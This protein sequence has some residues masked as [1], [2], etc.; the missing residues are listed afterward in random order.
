[1]EKI[2][3]D[4]VIELYLSGIGSTTIVKILKLPKKSILKLLKEKGLIRN[5][6]HSEEFYSNFWE[7]NG[8]WCG[9]WKCDTCERSIKFTVNNKS[10][11]NRNI[12]RKKTCKQCSLDKQ[13]GDGNPFYGKTHTQETIS[14]ISKSRIGQYC[15]DNHHMK[16]PEKLKKHTEILRE[17]WK[18]GELDYLRPIRRD[19]MI[20]TRLE[21]KLKS[22]IRSKAEDEIILA[23]RNN[24][25]EVIPNYRIETKIFD[26]Y[27][28]K[29]NLLIEYNG[30]YWHCN[31]K[32][33]DAD[34][35]NN[36]KFKTAKEI[37]EYDK[38]KLY[39]AK[40]NGYVCEVI[41]EMDYK[42][43]KDIVLE[44]IKKYEDK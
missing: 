19:K 4:K 28:P 5:R 10:L 13:V 41:W 23:L 26:L 9:Y 43:N 16:N 11:L 24:L 18:S 32:K 12:K 39:L 22:F 35:Y 34:Y 44:I 29:Y 36:K 37:W 30:D 8:K 2:I 6:L 42:K 25:V 27:L 31:P 40:K 38:N 3:E 14:E 7:E 17:K 20:E 33:Y 15:G 21:G 1:M